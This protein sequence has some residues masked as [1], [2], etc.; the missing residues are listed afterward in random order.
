MLN[1]TEYQRERLELIEHKLK[2]FTEKPLVACINGLLDLNS[3][4]LYL[5]E[6]ITLAGGRNVAFTKGQDV[7]A[8]LVEQDPD[9]IVI[10]PTSGP[11][12]AVMGMMP[13]LL[14]QSGFGGVK[15]VK[16]NRIYIIET[17]FFNGD[18]LDQV[19]KV[20]LLAEIIYPKQFI[21]GYEGQGWIKFGV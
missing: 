9:I 6:L 1:L 16:N 7:M 19:D 3:T 5:D 8:N 18:G 10:A 14:Q 4:C 12:M 2:F 17:E 21:F 11:A 20:E 13:T 15:A